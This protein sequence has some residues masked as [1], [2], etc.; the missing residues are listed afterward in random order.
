[1]T[2]ADGNLMKHASRLP[3]FCNLQGY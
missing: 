3:F 1:M 2:C